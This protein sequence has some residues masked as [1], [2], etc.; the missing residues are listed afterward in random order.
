MRR[1]PIIDDFGDR[2]KGSQTRDFVS[3]LEVETDFQPI[4]NKE[5]IILQQHGALQ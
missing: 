3:P 4:A 1:T 2:G 5:I